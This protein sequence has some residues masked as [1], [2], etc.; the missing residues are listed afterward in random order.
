MP[1]THHDERANRHKRD[2]VGKKLI[3]DRS[4]RFVRIPERN[5]QYAAILKLVEKHRGAHRQVERRRRIEHQPGQIGLKEQFQ[6]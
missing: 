6:T 5:D 3:D 1:A 4:D 2:D